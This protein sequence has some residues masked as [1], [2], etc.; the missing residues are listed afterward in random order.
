MADSITLTNEEIASSLDMAVL[1]RGAGKVVFTTAEIGRPG[2]Q[3]AGYYSHFAQK[4]VQLIG[5][6]ETDYLYGM[7]YAEAF[8]RLDRFMSSGI[9]CVVCAR[10]NMPPQA[11]IDCAEKYAVPVFLSA[12][13]TDDIGHR[14][15]NYLSRKLAPKALIHGV[16]LDVFG[17]GILL[18]GASGMGKSETALEMIKQ[19]HRLVADDVVELTRVTDNR[20][21]GRAPEVT[22]CMIEVRG[23][24]IVDV[25]YLFGVGA[26]VEEKSVELVM[27][28]EFW[29]ADQEYD[30]LGNGERTTQILGVSVPETVLPVSPGR[31]L[32]VVVEVAA[33]NFLLK[34]MGYDTSGD[35]ARKA[36]SILEGRE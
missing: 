12:A 26:V 9:P 24:G 30:R 4:R 14:I 20:L 19:G 33:R 18:R 17:V 10:N 5:N 25:R 11:L 23:I 21:V 28:L 16:L 7:E 32:A 22:R 13:L 31:N 36:Q 15:T 6:S 35:F 8:D 29:Q 3:L 1:V 27:D 2:L 34:R